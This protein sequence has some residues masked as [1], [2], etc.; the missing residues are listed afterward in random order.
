MLARLCF[1]LKST[2]THTYTHTHTLPHI[3]L[4]QSPSLSAVEIQS[5]PCFAARVVSSFK[6]V[7]SLAGMVNC[8]VN[9]CSEIQS[10][11][12]SLSLSLLTLSTLVCSSITSFALLLLSSSSSSLLSPRTE[13]QSF[14][15]L[16]RSFNETFF[17]FSS[18]RVNLSLCFG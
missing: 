13:S 1:S 6:H 17:C 9:I 11:S 4:P 16:P 12:L 14:K 8:C 5:H 7:F 10:V 18:I 3:F 15:I 2:H